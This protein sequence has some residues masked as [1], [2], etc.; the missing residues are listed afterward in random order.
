MS[1]AIPGC[2][3]HAEHHLG[4]RLRRPDTTAIWAP[5]TNV[6]LCDDH[7]ISGLRIQVLLIPTGTGRIQTDVL[8]TEDQ[9]TTRRT[10]IR[11]D[12]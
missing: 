5:N 9:G 12:P 7:A 1:C 8:A 10:S 4:V 3:D 2:S 11:N 6:F